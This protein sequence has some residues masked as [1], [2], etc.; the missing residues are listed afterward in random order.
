MIKI[1]RLDDFNKTLIDISVEDD[2]QKRNSDGSTSKKV[3]YYVPASLI[4]KIND[5][6]S[7]LNEITE[8]NL[9][10]SIMNLEKGAD[11]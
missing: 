3:Y 6:I 7:N 11:E 2:Y 8:S 5:I 4:T 9:G 10:R 1:E